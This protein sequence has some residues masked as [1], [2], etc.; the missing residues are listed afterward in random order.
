[1]NSMTQNKPMAQYTQLWLL[2]EGAFGRVYLAE[3]EQGVLVAIKQADPLS[4]KHEQEILNRIHTAHGQIEG[5]PRVLDAWEDSD[6]RMSLV[7]DYI[8]GRCLQHIPLYSLQL[9]TVIRYISEFFMRMTH[10]HRC[11]VVHYDLHNR[12][13][14]EGNDG[15]VYLIDF[16]LSRSAD[17]NL[18][19]AL[20]Y[21][22]ADMMCVAESW[23]TL[24][25]QEEDDHAPLRHALLT[26]LKDSQGHIYN[27]AWITETA[28]SFLDRWYTQLASLAADMEATIPLSHRYPSLVPAS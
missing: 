15:H 8:P 20:R 2:G 5:I 9:S 7:L 26:W 3:N 1:M 17:Q 13:I 22:V 6:D 21:E 16:G 4:L 27:D 18:P 14:L 11:G 12:N 24:F 25:V 10:L 23:L 28:V 19:R